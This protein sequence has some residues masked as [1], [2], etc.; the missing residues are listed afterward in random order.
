MASFLESSRLL[1]A[2]ASGLG[3]VAA[4]LGGYG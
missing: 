2:N 3:E 1:I 4:V